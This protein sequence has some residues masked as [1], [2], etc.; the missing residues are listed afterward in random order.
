MAPLGIRHL[1]MPVKPEHLWR[2]IQQSQ[3]K[4]A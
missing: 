2:I 1:D 4:P 3:K